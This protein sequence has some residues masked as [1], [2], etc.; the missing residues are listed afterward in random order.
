M[1]KKLLAVA[2]LLVAGVLFSACTP[3][4][5]TTVVAPEDEMMNDE[6]MMEDTSMEADS[7][8]GGMGDE[9][10]EEDSMGTEGGVRTPEG[11][12]VDELPPAPN[13]QY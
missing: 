12:M 13:V 4:E 6:M 5:E 7:M 9:M 2:A 1:P 11:E 8:D 3:A 10:M